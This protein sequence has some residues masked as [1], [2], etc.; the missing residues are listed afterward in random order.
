MKLY[1]TSYQGNPNVGL[2]GF[3]TD[4]Y[5]LLAPEFPPEQVKKIEEAL[6]VPAYQIRVA[7][8]SLL[9]ALVTGNDTVLLIPSIVREDELFR[10]KQLKIPYHIISTKL[11]ALG[12]NILCNNNGALV[13]R[14]YSADTKKIIRQALNVTL[15]PG[16]I[17]DTTV[18]G[19]CVVHNKKAAV[20]HA[21]ATQEQIKEVEDLLGVTCVKATANFGSPYLRSGVI[22]NSFGMVIGENSTGIEIENIYE[23]LG[24]LDQ[25]E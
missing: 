5:C 16:E 25:N 21:F 19:S 23:A 15:H 20:I 8:S 17:A 1:K 24:F 13:N 10:L 18:P 22:A 7:N 4:N 11:T 9:G 3:A 6:H 12:N 2:Y 14:D